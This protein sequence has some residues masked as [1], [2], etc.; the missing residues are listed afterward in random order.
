MQLN[1]SDINQMASG[2][3]YV[4]A[5]DADIE[6][7]D[8]PLIEV[9]VVAIDPADAD[10]ELVEMARLAILE[11]ASA[12]LSQTGRG[13]FVRVHRLVIHPTDFQPRHFARCTAV[14]LRRAFA[15]MP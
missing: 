3:S 10:P 12:V 11:G 2:G 8:A 5:Y 7:S 1:V 4:V 14:E 13:A 9:E 6:L 15:N